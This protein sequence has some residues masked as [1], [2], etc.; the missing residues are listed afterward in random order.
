MVFPAI[1]HYA[2]GSVFMIVMGWQ[3]FT[4]TTEAR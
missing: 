1:K 3:D 4:V 2:N